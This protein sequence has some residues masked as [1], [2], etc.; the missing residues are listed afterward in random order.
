MSELNHQARK[1]FGQNFLQDQNIIAKIIAAARF[2]PTDQVLEIGPGLG[3]LTKPLLAQLPALEVIELDR[4]LAGALPNL[5]HA[6]KLTIYQ[7]DA[8]KFDFASDSPRR[9]IG[10]LPYNISSPLLFHLLEYQ[11][12]IVDMHFM[13]QKEV[14]ERLA[15]TPQS[16]AYGRISVMLQA[17]AKVEYLFSVPPSAFK[18]A[19]KVT[20]AVVRISPYKTP[21]YAILDAALFAK[22][23]KTAFAMR[24]KTLHNNLKTTLAESVFDHCGIAKNARAEVLT[25]GDFVRLAN[26]CAQNPQEL[27]CAI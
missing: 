20:S 16:R 5:P 14:V 27:R 4:D 2:A 10:N 8:L 13:L 11:K 21:K 15:A 7:A 26:Y 19:P 17:Y 22:L 9:I 6:D 3:A 12:S 1:R 23:V 24:R 25:V 18:P